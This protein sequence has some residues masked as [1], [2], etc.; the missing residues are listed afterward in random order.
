MTPEHELPT[1]VL[2][3]VL[4]LQLM[5]AWAGEEGD[6]NRR[7]GWWRC[8]LTDAMTG[9]DFF[10]RTTPETAGWTAMDAARRAAIIVDRESRKR[11]GNPDRIRTLF[12][13]GHAIDEQ[14]K[15]RLAHLKRAETP[16]Q[17]A[18]SMPDGFMAAFDQAS[19]QTC[20]CTIHFPPEVTVTP[21][22][23]QL[24]GPPPQAPEMVGARLASALA[25]LTKNYPMPFYLLPN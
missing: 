13:F 15:F 24:K 8:S 23:R 20:L 3:E 19:F 1:S 25:P 5:V 18:L 21:T 12:F 4:A 11:H 6:D 10:D 17:K 2:D 9:A 16:I 14:L 7:L 22:G